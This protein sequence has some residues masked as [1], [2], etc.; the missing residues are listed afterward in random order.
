VFGKQNSERM[1]VQKPWDHTI[2]LQED[3]T[4]KK[5]R[6]YPLSRTE[7]EEVQAFVDSQLKKGYIQLSKSPQTLLVMNHPYRYLTSHNG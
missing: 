2:D 6:I 3:F 5:G 4:P 7:K 1:P